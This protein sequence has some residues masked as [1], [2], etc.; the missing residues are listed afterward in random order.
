M[1][2][3]K[4]FYEGDN[5][6][7]SRIENA[8]N[9]LPEEKQLRVEKTILRGLSSLVGAGIATLDVL[10]TGNP[11][12]SI[13]IPAYN[14]VNLFSNFFMAESSGIDPWLFV[15][16]IKD[17]SKERGKNTITYVLGASVPFAINY[18]NEIIN[19]LYHAADKLF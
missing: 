1:V 17:W 8:W 11:Y 16:D 18:H 13:G 2:Y 15:D 12:F 6:L 10:T 19:F 7:F 4:R 5:G 9:G 3:E 14:A